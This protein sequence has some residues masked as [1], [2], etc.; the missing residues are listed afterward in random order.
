MLFSGCF[1]VVFY[2][3]ITWKQ[4]RNNLETTWK[5]PEKNLETTWKQPGNN[6]ETIEETT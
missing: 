2:L 5:Q 1:Y 4:P 6:L 3:E